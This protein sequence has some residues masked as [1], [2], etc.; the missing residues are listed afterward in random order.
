MVVEI[1]DLKIPELTPYVSL[2]GGRGPGNDVIIAESPKVIERGLDAGFQPISLLCERK[3]I[4]GDAAHII[5]RT[6]GIPIYTG[7]RELLASLTGYELTRGVLCAFRRPP[8]TSA[9]KLLV[10]SR[11]VCVIYDVCDATNIGVIFRSAAALGY[12]CVILSCRTC[13]PYNRRAVRVSM[14]AVFQIPWSG[15]TDVPVM[16]SKFGFKG[17]SMALADGSRFLQDFPVEAGEKYAVILGSEGYGLPQEIISKSTYT[18]KIPMAH[19]VD[20]LNVGAAAAI[21]LWHFRSF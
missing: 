9:E 21:A 5:E 12:D 11:R 20:S 10:T 18:V 1:E 13:D 6:E 17:V 7:D 19:G 4:R 15:V 8:Q 16:L 3:H 14:G 2:T